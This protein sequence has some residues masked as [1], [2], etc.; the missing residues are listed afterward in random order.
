MDKPKMT[1]AERQVILLSQIFGLIPGMRTD[2]AREIA[3]AMSAKKRRDAL[4]HFAKCIG[5]VHKKVSV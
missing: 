5:A 3:Y 4:I 1:E 2:V